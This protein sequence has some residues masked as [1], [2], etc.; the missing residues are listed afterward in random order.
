MDRYI[1]TDLNYEYAV[2]A[3]NLWQEYFKMFE[4]TQIMWQKDSKVF[5]EILN[6]L[7]ED[8]HTVEDINKIK[9]RLIQEN[10]TDDP[11]YVPQ[12]F[13]QNAKVTQFN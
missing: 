3:G 7:Q 6:R 12:L 11:K 5:A 10:S 2:L 4:L 13:I 9:E 8:N 1:F